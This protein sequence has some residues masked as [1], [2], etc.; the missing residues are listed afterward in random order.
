MRVTALDLRKAEF[1]VRL[2]GYDADD[3]HEWLELAA[4]EIE[5]LSAENHSLRDEL[6]DAVQKLSEVREKDRLLKDTL[7]EAQRTRHS[8]EESSKKEAQLIIAEAELQAKQLLNESYMKL[9]TIRQTMIDLRNEKSRVRHTM[10]AS[11]EVMIKS[12]DRDEKEDADDPI[13]AQLHLLEN[14]DTKVG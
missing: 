4:E 1:R 3:V 10:R 5:R 11:L 7:F 2:R 8:L 13:H 14:V 6:K 12:I 9:N